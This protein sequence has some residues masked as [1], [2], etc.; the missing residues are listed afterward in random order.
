MKS[1]YKIID[2]YYDEKDANKIEQL[3]IQ[4]IEDILKQRQ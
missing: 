1:V 4:Y 2:T 3:I